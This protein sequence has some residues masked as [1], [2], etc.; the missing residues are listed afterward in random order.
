MNYTYRDYLPDFRA[1]VSPWSNDG[2]HPGVWGRRSNIIH[3]GFKDSKNIEVIHIDRKIFDCEAILDVEN[4]KLYLMMTEKNLKLCQKKYSHKGFS[5]HYVFSL[6]HYNKNQEAANIQTSFFQ[7]LT[8]D[9]NQYRIDDSDQILSDWAD[10]VDEVI[11]CAFNEI[12][13]A[14]T[15]ATAYLFDA[16]Y[17]E[18]E[19][20]D[21]SN[22]LVQNTDSNT[23]LTTPVKPTEH[24]DT[25]IKIKFRKKTRSQEENES[26]SNT[27]DNKS[28]DNK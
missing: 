15:Q 16:Y 3:D 14:V 11:I 23:D 10:A 18:V 24:L 13:G 12:N 5:T 9:Q 22:I 8:D 21:I 2:L 25:Q 20:E 26:H 4:N 7:T 27:T 28:A 1:N 6:L 17:N 19:S